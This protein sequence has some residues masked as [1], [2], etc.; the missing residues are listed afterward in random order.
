M[1]S[2]R[3]CSPGWTG[4]RSRMDR[5]SVMV[6]DN[7][8]ALGAA[9]RPGEADPPLVVDPDAVLADTVSPQGFQPVARRRRQVAQVL[10][11]VDLAQLA[12]RHALDV[13][14]KSPG[15]PAMEQSLGVAVG[16]AADH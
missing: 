6:I 5:S 7:L 8:D 4:G 9:L 12:L 10:R 2:S 16:K 14:W 3:R 15:E 11:R 1:K 13:A